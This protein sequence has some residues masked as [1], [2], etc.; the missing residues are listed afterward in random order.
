M[1]K[2]QTIRRMKQF[3]IYSHLI[4]QCQ[5][6][7]NKADRNWETDNTT[8]IVRNCNISLSTMDR[9]SM[10]RSINIKKIWAV[11]Q[12]NSTNLTFIE[13][14]SHP[15]N[16]HS[17]K[18]TWRFLEDKSYIFHYMCVC[19]CMLMCVCVCVRAHVHV[20]HLFFIH[21]SLDGHLG[22]LHRLAL[23]DNAAINV[24]VHVP[25]QICIFVPFA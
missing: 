20:Y 7:E 1:I 18:C 23:V 13:H 2:Y 6:P 14:S 8:V 3:C 19:V 17:F 15:Q 21:S 9:T 11:L 4:T 10:Q 16:T 5:I 24:G 22:S 25:L 12:T